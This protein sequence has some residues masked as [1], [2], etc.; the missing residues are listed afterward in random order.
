MLPSAT[1]RPWSRMTTRSTRPSSSFSAWEESSTVVPP[2]AQRG[3]HLVELLAHRR[4][5]AARRLVEQQRPRDAEQ[6]LGQAEALAHALGVG[7]DRA[8]RAA[9]PGRRASKAA[10]EP[11]PAHPSGG[12]RSGGSRGRS[13]RG[14]RRRSPAAS[15][16]AARARDARGGILAEH[17]ER[18]RRWGGARPSIIFICV[19]LPAPLWPTRATTSPALGQ[20]RRRRGRR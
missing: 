15:R 1:T 10:F 6:R 14:G 8:R 4:V 12:R 9:W 5:E 18:C 2:P 3:E 19:V 16:A 7:A 13:A 17:A 20:A 11:R